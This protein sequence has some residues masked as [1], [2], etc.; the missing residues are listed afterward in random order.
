MAI[1]DPRAAV[2][3]LL[4]GDSTTVSGETVEICL[5]EHRRGA[6]PPYIALK[7]TETRSEQ[8]DIGGTAKRSHLGLMSISVITTHTEAADETLL[9]AICNYVDTTLAANICGESGFLTLH[10]RGWANAADNDRL[11]DKQPYF[12]RVLIYEAFDL[13]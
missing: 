6:H 3:T 9:A 12:H 5:W 2:K 4:G 10:F 1:F 11:T 13:E 8:E 7:F